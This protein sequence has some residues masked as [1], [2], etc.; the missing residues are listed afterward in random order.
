MSFANG[1]LLDAVPGWEEPMLLSKDDKVALLRD[2]V[3]R[4]RLGEIAAGKHMMRH[5]TNW[6]KMTI[7]HTVA[8]ENVATSVAT[9]VRS[10]PSAVRRHGTRC[11]RSHSPT[12]WR[13]LS[14]IRPSRSP[15]PTGRR[16]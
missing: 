6:A 16:A 10:L 4:A 13:R 8:P 3:E 7:F 5:F 9:S 15:P 1:F 14:V 12:T 2:P 11:A